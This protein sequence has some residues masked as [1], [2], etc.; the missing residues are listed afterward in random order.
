MNIVF[1]SAGKPR[2]EMLADALALSVRNTK[3]TF[4]KRWNGDYGE[5]DAG[6]DR[7][8]PGPSKDTDV[9]CVFGVK[10]RSRA[11]L[12]DHWLMGKSTLF[13][14]K[15]Y[16]RQKGEGGHTEYSRISVNAASPA[17]YMM[18]R[19]CSTDRWVKLNVNLQPRQS[20]GGHVLICGSSG[21]YHEFHRIGDPTEYNVK[22]VKRLLKLTSR[23]L[24]YRPKPSDH[25]AR[26]IAGASYSH[27][28]CSIIQ[29]LRG[30]HCLVT[31]GSASAMDAI[32]QGVPAIV[33]GKGVASPV[34]ENDLDKIEEAR[35]PTYDDRLRWC[36]ALAYCQ[37]TTQELREGIAW[38]HLRREIER[39]KAMPKP[40]GGL[41][42]EKPIETKD[43]KKKPK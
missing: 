39:Q 21:K 6:D 28:E 3:D 29:A 9:V 24:I 5:T 8:Y 40:L 10:G 23:Q 19:K 11:I 7:K 27:G 38:D 25:A 2:E 22:I 14:D 34:A 20:K 18:E 1:Y 12:E 33:L 17:D 13:F 42:G 15:G 31:H 26:P 4:E 35:F 37:W 43:Q 30:A 32:I 16:S 41:G 36:F